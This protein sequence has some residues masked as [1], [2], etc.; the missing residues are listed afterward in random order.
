MNQMETTSKHFSPGLSLRRWWPLLVVA[1]VLLIMGFYAVTNPEYLA[2]DPLLGGADIA[3]YA[4]CHRITERSFTVAGR[5]FPLCA[6]CTGMY[7]GVFLTFLVLLL[8]GRSRW[9]ELPPLPIMLV[10]VGFIGLMGIDGVN[11][12]S[13]LIPNAPHLY[14]PSNTL[15]LVTGMGTG[16]AMGL[17]IFPATVQTLWRV[18]ERR[19]IISGWMEFAGL[20]ILALITILLVL[21]NRQ[22]LLYVLAV[23]SAAGV[24]IILTCLNCILLLILLRRDARANNWR[25]CAGPLLLGLAFA[26]VEIGLIAFARFSLTGTMTGLPG[27]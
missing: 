19:A 13:Y 10:L 11:S 8:A 9:R 3:G 27:L 16:L 22:A 15:R 21:S 25:Q 23:V 24:V 17:F 20:L 6:R 1:G 12:F 18:S 14:Q 4:F 2:H 26:I 5:Q 7:L